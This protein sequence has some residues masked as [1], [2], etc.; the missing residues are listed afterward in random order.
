M[1]HTSQILMQ[2]KINIENRE[3]IRNNS[4]FWLPFPLMH[5]LALTLFCSHGKYN[6]KKSCYSYKILK[7]SQNKIDLKVKIDFK[8]K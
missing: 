7:F 4:K 1:F 6:N 8:Q 5:R 3:L 2:S